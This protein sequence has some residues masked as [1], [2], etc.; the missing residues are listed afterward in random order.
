MA[1]PLGMLL[2]ALGQRL[3]EDLLPSVYAAAS[4]PTAATRAW[5]RESGL[6]FR[7]PETGSYPPADEL[8]RAAERVIRQARGRSTA[9]G[10]AGGLGGA[11]AIPPEVLAQLVHTL[12]LAQRLAVIYGIDPETDGGR[13]LMWRALAAA[14]ELE[15]PAEGQVGSVRV[16]D[17]PDLVR[18]QLPA[19]RQAAAWLAQQV[20][21]RTAQLIAGRITRIIP[22][23]GAGLAGWRANRRTEEMAKRMVEVYQKVADLEPFLLDGEVDAIEVGGRR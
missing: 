15:L 14:Y 17:L 9:M 11:V 23:L 20:A 22:G 5:L 10:V 19:S 13:I 6:A 4:A 16:R 12:R 18:R 2:D 7:D 21:V 8:A 3:D 1:S